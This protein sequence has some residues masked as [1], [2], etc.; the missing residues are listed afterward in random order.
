MMN[1]LGFHYVKPEHRREAQVAKGALRKTCSA[2]RVAP[3]RS[4]DES[5]LGISEP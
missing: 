5:V 3:L 1:V 4:A 2:R